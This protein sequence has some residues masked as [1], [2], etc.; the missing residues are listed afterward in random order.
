MNRRRRFALSICGH[1]GCAE[2]VEESYCSKHRRAP[3]AGSMGRGRLPRV[4]GVS[5]ETGEPH[6]NLLE[7]IWLDS[8]T[9]SIW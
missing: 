4:I 1:R 2:L 3:W 6:G 9:T 8:P 7:V 5:G